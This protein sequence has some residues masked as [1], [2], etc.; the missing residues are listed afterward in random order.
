MTI[1]LLVAIAILAAAFWVMFLI[2]RVDLYEYRAMRKR[3]LD[4]QSRRIDPPPTG[5]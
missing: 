4:E 5:G 1:V 2:D 3:Y